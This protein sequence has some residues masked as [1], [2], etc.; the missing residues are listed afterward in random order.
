VVENGNQ[1]VVSTYIDAA[2]I[3]YVKMGVVHSDTYEQS[4]GMSANPYFHGRGNYFANTH[5]LYCMAMNYINGNETLPTDKQLGIKK[6]KK[7]VFHQSELTGILDIWQKLKDL[8][9]KQ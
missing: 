4:K 7:K 2:N 8:L 5:Y 9:E 3:D 1:N 6:I